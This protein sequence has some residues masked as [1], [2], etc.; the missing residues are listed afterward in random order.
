MMTL[1]EQIASIM[2]KR[3]LY[4]ESYRM[5]MASDIIAL[6]VEK[7]K[8]VENPYKHTDGPDY[9]VYSGAIEDVIKELEG[10]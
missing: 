3:S 10:K 8:G 1:Q 2:C 6:I 9:F 5:E 7:V 4:G